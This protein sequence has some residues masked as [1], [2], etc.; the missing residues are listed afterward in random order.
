MAKHKSY[1]AH[2]LGKILLAGPDAPV[3]V[4][5]SNNASKVELR[6]YNEGD[7]QW[8]PQGIS[9]KWEKYI[10]EEIIDKEDGTKETKQNTRYRCVEDFEY[11]QVTE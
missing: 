1:S 10:E 8:Y 2:Q 9:E 7:T 6:R 11:I 3:I 4:G 5:Y